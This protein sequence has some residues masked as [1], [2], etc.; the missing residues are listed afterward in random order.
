[1]IGRFNI[2]NDPWNACGQVLRLPPACPG[3]MVSHDLQLN[4]RYVHACTRIMRK[5]AAS[6]TIRVY[7]SRSKAEQVLEFAVPHPSRSHLRLAPVVVGVPPGCSRRITLWFCPPADQNEDTCP[8]ADASPV[9]AAP[10]TKPE[11]TLA[12]WCQQTL[13]RPHSLTFPRICPHRA[14]RGASTAL[15]HLARS[16]RPPVRPARGQAR[17]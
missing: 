17:L 1:M 9:K 3:D 14:W 16:S 7:V 8:H 5:M 15:R 2:H 12:S 10:D 11:V 13:C 4:N 6:L